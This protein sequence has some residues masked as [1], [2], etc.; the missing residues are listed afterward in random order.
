[1]S[2]QFRRRGDVR[3][4]SPQQEP[5]FQNTAVQQPFVDTAVY[6]QMSQPQGYEPRT[7]SGFPQNQPHSQ[8]MQNMQHSGA[9]AQQPTQ[10]YFQANNGTSYSQPQS[11]GNMQQPMLNSA[12]GQA[13]GMAQ[14]QMGP[15]QQ[16]PNV[17][18][19][20]DAYMHPVQASQLTGQKNNFQG[21]NQA[22]QMQIPHRP[23]QRQ[24]T[25]SANYTPEDVRSLSFWQETNANSGFEDHDEL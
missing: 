20:Q 6:P 12:M 19:I 14:P 7:N 11:Q 10:P 4:Q 21:Y 16:Y 17:M 22:A 2:F 15:Q 23:P 1:M 5:F 13:Y 8:Q 18:N 25:S 3:E 9:F 24:Q